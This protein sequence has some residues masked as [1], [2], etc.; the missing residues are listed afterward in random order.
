[1]L[2]GD[3]KGQ[4]FTLTALRSIQIR[5]T[6]RR[7]C[8]QAT[9]ELSLV[10]T[11]AKGVDAQPLSLFSGGWVARLLGFGR[12]YRTTKLVEAFLA[13]AVRS[14][15]LL[16]S[17]LPLSL[18]VRGPFSNFKFFWRLLNSPSNQVFVHP[19]TRQLVWDIRNPA[20][21]GLAFKEVQAALV[22]ALADYGRG[23]VPVANFQ[24][25]AHE[26]N[27]CAIQSRAAHK[28]PTRALA[29]YQ[30]EWAQLIFTPTLVGRPRRAKK[31]RSIRKRLA[32]RLVRAAGRRFWV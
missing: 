18:C 28:R 27:L 14:Y 9:V 3:D 30:L 16:Y 22:T 4:L 32:K 2:A 20:A 25:I 23:Q 13:T 15:I 17:F 10:T 19:L 7:R 11:L 26:A 24:I 12:R 1:M 29:R 6:L 5:A 21:V 31:A 8:R